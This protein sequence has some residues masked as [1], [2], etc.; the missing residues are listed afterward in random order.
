MNQ[1]LDFSKIIRDFKF[2]E[3]EKCIVKGCGQI[4]TH[5]HPAGVGLCFNCYYEIFNEVEK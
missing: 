5:L 1:E 3:P 2:K 4:A